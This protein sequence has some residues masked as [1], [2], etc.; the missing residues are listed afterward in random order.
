[1]TIVLHHY[2]ASPFSEQLRLALGLKNAEYWSVT[3][4]NVAPKPLLTPLT[5]GYR[6]TPVLQVDADI[7]CGTAVAIAAIEALPGP[8]LFPASL[9][10]T[11]ALVAALA[12]GAMFLPAV[13]TALLPAVDTIPEAFWA[14][15]RAL[16]GLDRALVEDRA[17]HYRAQF[18]AGCAALEASLADGRDFVGGDAPGHAD[19]A[20]YM[21]VWVQRRFVPTA[22]I[23]DP[24]PALL[25]WEARV[26]AVGH[27]RPT[28]VEA[29]EALALAHGA[30]PDV[31][32]AVDA[33]S[34]FTAGQPVTVTTDDPGA[35]AVTGRLVRLSD[36]TVVIRRDDPDTGTVA[37][38]FPRL[39]QIL[40]AA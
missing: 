21:N 34:G 12:G 10:A 17:P 9:G 30:A 7:Y 13:A 18:L 33:S 36:S 26:R 27:G 38:H 39:G 2:A 14:D 31:A 6:K 22:P 28:S 1:M 11:G 32:E 15:R 19:F 16:F 3:V 8:S 37:V 5:G 25:A 24:F 20:L 35:T 4:P 29:E 40:T 23:L